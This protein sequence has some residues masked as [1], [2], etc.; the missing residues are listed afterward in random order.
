MKIMMTGGA[1]FIG[2]NLLD[3]LLLP[4]FAHMVSQI[5]VLDNF[6]YAGS[7]ANLAR[8][9]DDQRVTV[10]P[11]DIC[12]AVLV[13]DLMSNVDTVLHLAAETH[14]DRSIADALKF[15]EANVRGTYVMLDAARR[16]R[17][18]RFLHISTDE[19]Y[20]VPEPGHRFTE[21]DILRPRNP[22]AASKAAA[23]LM[24]N[25]FKETF[26]LPLIIA[27]SSNNVGPRQY[28][29]K[30]VPRFATNALRGL[31]LTVHGDG[32]QMR[33]WLYVDD[34]C[35]A[36]ALLLSDGEI[37]G[38]YNIG[39][40]QEHSVNEVAGIILDELCIDVPRIFVS[41]RPGNDRLYAIETGRMR[42]LGWAARHSFEEALRRTARWYRDNPEWWSVLVET[43][44]HERSVP[45][46]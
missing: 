16:H 4:A 2:S 30:L 39:A 41:D 40:H 17:V 34:N 8:A 46:D 9:V 19:V 23:E 32:Q 1:G 35:E 28:I 24:C 6:T 27:R 45:L 5:V 37:G 20:G 11:G 38:I 36:L 44:E 25:S 18:Q 22:Y 15:I 12:S 43:E 7:H 14:V 42:A 21:N 31:P 3:H 13:N 29:E 26:D 10:V 33:D